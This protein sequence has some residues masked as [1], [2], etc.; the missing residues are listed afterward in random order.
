MKNYRVVIVEDDL[1]LKESL[2][3]WLSR[4]YEVSEHESAED[5]LAAINDFDFEDGLPTCMLLDFQMPGMNGVELQ[6]VLKS[7]NI[8]YP[9]IFMS[10]NAQQA[11]V[12]D[13]WREGAVDF[14]LKP[15]SGPQISDCLQRLFSKSLQ[16]KLDSEPAIEVVVGNDLPI[17]P[18]EAEVLLLLGQGHRQAE[19]AAMLGIGLRT[20]KM[21]RTSL[22]N[23]LNLN[24]LVELSRFCDQHS[25]SIQ[26]IIG[27]TD[28]FK[29]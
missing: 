9:I 21:H 19:V 28:P 4:D 25:L 12:I 17:T 26:K 2:K 8:E 29:Q 10:G 15:F 11:D 22:K 1:A 23:K 27:K 7:M 6:R 3:D 16:I 18:R 13:A 14:L 5:F 24:T 20:I